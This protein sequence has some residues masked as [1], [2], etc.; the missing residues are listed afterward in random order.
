MVT[1]RLINGERFIG[2]IKETRHSVLV[3]EDFKTGKT[4]EVPVINILSIDY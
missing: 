4:R 2:T 1:F 3:I